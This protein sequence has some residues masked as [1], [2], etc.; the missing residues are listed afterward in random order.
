MIIVPQLDPDKVSHELIPVFI[1]LQTDADIRILF[2]RLLRFIASRGMFGPNLLWSDKKDCRLFI[3]EDGDY[4][5]GEEVNMVPR[6]VISG[7]G[8][9]NRKLGMSGST[10]GTTG[11]GA[12]KTVN[13]VSSVVLDITGR[14][15]SEAGRIAEICNDFIDILTPEIEA[16]VTN[17]ESIEGLSWV[18]ARKVSGKS[19]DPYEWK[20]GVSFSVEY[21]KSYEVSRYKGLGISPHPKYNRGVH[22]GAAD[23][24]SQAYDDTARPLFSLVDFKVV[25]GQDDDEFVVV[26]KTF[27]K[28]SE[29]EEPSFPEVMD[30]PCITPDQALLEFGEIIAGT[31]SDTLTS[32][33]S[34][35]T[36]GEQTVEVVLPEGAVLDVIHGEDITD[37]LFKVKK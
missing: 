30:T 26:H 18:G 4:D 33:V 16:S 14:S 27:M 22:L 3:H 28:N 24:Q 11:L 8:G 7:G 17:M 13:S 2:L 23:K 36:D 15:R 12:M 6:I 9:R 19:A 29:G 37:I 5:T 35:D 21:N 10:S 32:T 34:P 20:S 1:K 31:V 25:A